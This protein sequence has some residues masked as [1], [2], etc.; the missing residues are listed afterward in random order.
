MEQ[1][2]VKKAPDVLK[3]ITDKLADAENGIEARIYSMFKGNQYIMYVYKRYRDIQPGWY[4]TESV[5]KFGGDTD[6]WNGHAILGDFSVFRVYATK[7]GKP[8]D[9]STDNVPLKPKH[10]YR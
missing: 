2:R 4:T 7:E 1:K 10:F 3:A 5:G 9:Y 8:A 6:N